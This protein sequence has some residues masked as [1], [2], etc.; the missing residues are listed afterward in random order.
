MMAENT[1]ALPAEIFQGHRGSPLEMAD[2][3]L[4][5]LVVDFGQPEWTMD[6]DFLL[7]AETDHLSFAKETGLFHSG[8]LCLD[9]NL[10]L[11]DPKAEP[12]NQQ[13]GFGLDNMHHESILDIGDPRQSLFKMQFD[14]Y[15]L[16]NDNLPTI[17]LFD[18]EA[19]LGSSESS[20]CMQSPCSPCSSSSLGSDQVAP[21]T[22]PIS[23]ILSPS[24]EYCTDGD[25]PCESVP[26]EIL[27]VIKE[28]AA[29]DFDFEMSYL[30]ESEA[31]PEHTSAEEGES[32]DSKDEVKVEVVVPRAET[33]PKKCRR[34]PYSGMPKRGGGGHAFP[35]VKL[36]SDSCPSSPEASDS[37]AGEGRFQ[38][39]KDQNKTAATR[40]RQKKKQELEILQVERDKLEDRNRTLNEK[41]DS[42][43]REI[44]Y[45]RD[46]MA[47]IQMA[48]SLKK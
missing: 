12:L 25:S 46:L 3:P 48:R 8:G 16:Q 33:T 27:L 15:L 14:T 21:C 24:S 39:K 41:A 37:P 31:S 17:E 38:K 20:A 29:P 4:S 22:P 43:S 10:G 44:K 40:Y 26:Q 2:D 45:L 18:I 42:L 9:Q 36:V 5:G 19:N 7:E 11:T 1:T 32:F 6:L 35:K 28:P 23:P 47:E 30:T 13:P 34:T